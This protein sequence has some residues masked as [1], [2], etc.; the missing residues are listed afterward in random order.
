M[1]KRFRYQI[2]VFFAVI[3]PGFI[4]AV[5][6]ND[7]IPFVNRALQKRYPPGSTFKLVTAT[8]WLEQERSYTP[9]G[10]SP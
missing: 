10:A 9:L 2:G 5:V 8:A 7:D 1:L 3:G 4:T 6:D